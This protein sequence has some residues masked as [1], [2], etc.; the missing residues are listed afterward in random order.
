M[1][2]CPYC[3]EEILKVARKCKHC[4]STLVD[5]EEGSERGQLALERVSPAKEVTSDK[6]S[7]FPKGLLIFLA[8]AVC[9]VAAVYYLTAPSCDSESVKAQLFSLLEEKVLFLE[10]NGID[11][12]DLTMSLADITR[13]SSNDDAKSC[14]A[15]LIVKFSPRLTERLSALM[16]MG[17]S[18]LL[19]PHFVAQTALKNNW[20]D[21]SEELE[22]LIKYQHT[23]DAVMVGGGADGISLAALGQIIGY[24]G[25]IKRDMVVATTPKTPLSAAPSAPIAPAPNTTSPTTSEN[26]SGV[27]IHFQESV[28][29]PAAWP[30]VNVAGLL[31]AY[32]GK[33]MED[34][35]EKTRFQMLLGD[36][37]QDFGSALSVGSEINDSGDYLFGAG[38]AP[39]LCTGLESAYAI[40][41]KTGR[42]FAMIL[43]DGSITAFGGSAADMPEVLREWARKNGAKL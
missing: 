32:P 13:T 9:I 17:S 14:E 27:P 7:S 2:N 15:N 16:A 29:A 28:Q 25:E 5:S 39:H 36:K 30:A 8:V 19:T 38:C 4:H 43:N 11:H 3:G 35:A 24:V 1:K 23:R 6:E 10:R 42:P 41:K 33:V 22:I 31:G 34:A 18:N 26:P 40:N 37:L 20:N 21:K 12:E